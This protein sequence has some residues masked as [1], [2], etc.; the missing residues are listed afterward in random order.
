[1]N[2]KENIENVLEELSEEV[3][4]VLENEH[5]SEEQANQIYKKQ[6]I[7]LDNADKLIAEYEKLE[8]ELEAE[9]ESQNREIKE[10]KIYEK[11]NY[12]GNINSNN[13]KR[14][15]NKK[16]GIML[17]LLFL[18]LSIGGIKGYKTLTSKAHEEVKETLNLADPNTL[19]IVD[20][21]AEDEDKALNSKEEDKKN[22]ENGVKNG[23]K[24]I[25]VENELSKIQNST[26][27]NISAANSVDEAIQRDRQEI[28]EALADIE[29]TNKAEM[30]YKKDNKNTVVNSMTFFK[31]DNRNSIN[32]ENGKNID[33]DRGESKFDELYRKSNNLAISSNESNSSRIENRILNSYDYSILPGSVIPAILI[34]E[35]NTDIPGDIIAQVRENIY[36]T[37]TGKFLLVP[38]G[39]KLYGK[40]NAAVVNGQNR[41]MIAFDKLIL[42]NG[43]Y[44]NLTAMSGADNLG[45]SG[46][47]DKVNNH[48]WSLLGNAVLASILNFGNTMAKGISFSVGGKILG[49]NGKENKD[50]ENTSPFEKATGKIL[51]RAVDR[52]P[53]LTIRQG[54]IFNVI[55]N[56]E[57]VMQSY[58]Y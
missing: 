32:N 18:L 26:T 9:I 46:L 23:D 57:I 38:K 35:I 1:M 19:N 6:Q 33:K 45:R 44:V 50:N 7:I 42:P 52:K 41:V 2:Y 22:D 11:E 51:E 5:I 21:K 53:T 48:T 15:L 25:D 56:G 43:K 28:D 54:F 14:N 30:Q 10:N 49:L 13:N 58:K 31:K 20:I 16:K 34:T 47:N 40:Y 55:V 39:S 8:T 36:D 29:G 17:L 3:D 27:N 37:R 4:K 24:L 12:E